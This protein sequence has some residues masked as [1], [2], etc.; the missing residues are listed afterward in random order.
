MRTRTTP[1]VTLVAAATLVLTG[2]GGAVEPTASAPASAHSAATASD[3]ITLDN[4]W[5]KAA[6][7]GMTAG[8]GELKNSGTT[9]ITLV[10]VT[11]AAAARAELHE[12]VNNES[13]EMMMREKDGGFTVPAGGSLL[14]EP[15]ANHIMLMALT[16]PIT[17]GD[18]VR[19]TLTFSDDS[20]LTV[21]LPAKDYS[22]AN[23]N[24]DD[25]TTP[26]SDIESD[27]HAGHT[28]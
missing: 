1:L 11:T 19:F 27:E 14:L 10:A 18:D 3:L 15:G 6:E 12:T 9:D 5:V 23:E 8:F 25:A 17:A 24:Y 21:T 16:Q 22:G 2:C 13:G 4:A 20:T 26:H 7:T 28:K